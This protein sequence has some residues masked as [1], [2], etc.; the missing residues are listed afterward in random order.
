MNNRAL[1]LSIAMAA[2]AAYFVYSYVSSI[3][4]AQRKK[5]GSAVSVMVAKRDIKEM[6]D[7]QE[8]MLRF[9]T[10]P[11][12]FVEPGAFSSDLKD[13]KDLTQKLRDYTGMIALVPIKKGEQ[14][15]GSK[16]SEPNVRTGLSAQVSPGRRAVAIEV[17]E[18]TGV[19]KLVKPGDRVDVIGV[20]DSGGGKENKVSRIILQDVVV[21]SVGRYVTHNMPRIEEIDGTGARKVRNL[22]HDYNWA[23]ITLEV[24]PAQAQMLAL[25]SASGDSQLAL[26]LRNN[27]DSEQVAAPG[28]MLGDVL[29]PDAVRVRSP[30]GGRR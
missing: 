24:A 20:I 10:V 25:I 16:L 13:G 8:D 14:I 3:E 1:T 26:S 5:F 17:N 15:T 19:S 6:E 23:S 28:V 9:E 18:K 7:V 12:Q 4:D 30:A 11:R 2:L 22:L 27:E 21:L 29:G